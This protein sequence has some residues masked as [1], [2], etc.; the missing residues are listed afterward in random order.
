MSFDVPANNETRH[1]HV[2]GFKCRT[3]IMS[4]PVCGTD[5]GGR[6]V[7]VWGGVVDVYRIKPMRVLYTRYVVGRVD[8]PRT[9]IHI[10]LQGSCVG[11]I[12]ASGE[13]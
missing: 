8:T 6:G 4:E 2:S 5:S 12:A 3:I 10:T 9:N 1:I 7:C 13:M 11:S